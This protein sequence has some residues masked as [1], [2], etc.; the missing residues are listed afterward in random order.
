MLNELP[1]MMGFCHQ[2]ETF[3]FYSTLFALIII[4]TITIVIV[5]ASI[6]CRIVTACLF[7]IYGTATARLSFQL[8]LWEMLEGFHL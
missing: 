8:R 3:D 4:T 1:L 6:P 2:Q 7:V 5:A